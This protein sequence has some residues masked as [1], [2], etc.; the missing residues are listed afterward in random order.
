M[1]KLYH[2]YFYQ[3]L[4]C[5]DSRVIMTAVDKQTTNLKVKYFGNHSDIDEEYRTSG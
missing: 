3:D 5:F 1:G 2:L 4:F